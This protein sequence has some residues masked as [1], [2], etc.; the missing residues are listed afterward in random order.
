MEY[1]GSELTRFSVAAGTSYF[2]HE[3]AAAAP[4][5]RRV[6]SAAAGSAAALH[7]ASRCR[8]FSR[9]GGDGGGEGK[10]EKGGGGIQHTCTFTFNTNSL[11]VTTLLPTP[12]SRPR[13]CQCYGIFR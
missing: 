13:G 5:Q 12:I 4:D 2:V 6:R 9:G 11:K 1:V 3:R 10:L 7:A 8:H